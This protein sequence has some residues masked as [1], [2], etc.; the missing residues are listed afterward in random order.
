MK[1]FKKWGQLNLFALRFAKYI[2]LCNLFMLARLF[3]K[4]F[5][6]HLIGIIA[7]FGCTFVLTIISLI[8]YQR[9]LEHEQ[10]LLFEKNTEWKKLIKE[11]EDIKRLLNE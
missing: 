5:D 6:S 9:V 2:Q 10:G 3:I 11:I 7:L 8:D 1:L 4:S